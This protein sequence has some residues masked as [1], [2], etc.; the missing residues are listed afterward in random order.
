MGPA[1]ADLRGALRSPGVRD[2]LL[3][4]LAYLTALGSILSFVFLNAGTEP[5]RVEIGLL[6]VTVLL[7]FYVSLTTG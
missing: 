7:V 1:V 2:V 5:T 4:G 3:V 6:L